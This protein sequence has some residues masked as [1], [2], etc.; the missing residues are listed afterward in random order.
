MDLQLWSDF[1]I[2]ILITVK[3]SDLLGWIEIW[4]GTAPERK[5]PALPRDAY[6]ELECKN[7]SEYDPRSL[8]IPSCL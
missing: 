8:C 1:E 6:S 2:Q 4:R 5:P 3:T 7:Y